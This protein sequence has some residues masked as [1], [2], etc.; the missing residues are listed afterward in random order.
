MI[1]LLLIRFK[2]LNKKLLAP[3][4]KKLKEKYN[5]HNHLSENIF[6]SINNSLNKIFIFISKFF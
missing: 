6:Y 5:C 1:I 4:R 2:I 3:L